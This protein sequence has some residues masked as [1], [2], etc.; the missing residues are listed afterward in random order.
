MKKYFFI[1]SIFLII[2]FFLTGFSSSNGL[3]NFYFVIAIALDTSDSGI[4]LS[5]QIPSNSTQDSSGDSSSSQSSEY[6]LYSVEGETV[7]ECIS[8]LDNY[9][10]KEINLSHCSALIF[11]ENLAKQGLQTYINTF[12]NNTQLRHSC[13]III[14]SSTAFDILKNISNSGAIFSARLY[15]Y[16][17]SSSEYTGYTIKST[18]GEFFQALENDYYEPTAIYAMTS[19]DIVQTTGMAVFKSDSMIGTLDISNTISHLIAINK[20]DSAT[21]TLNNPF[22]VGEKIDLDINLYKSTD[23][24]VDIIN[25]SPLISINVY[26][27]GSI[28]SS[29]T[30]FNYIEGKNIKEVENATNKYLEKIFKKYVYTITKEYNSDIVGF[31]GICQSNYLTKEEFEK[32]HWDEIFK[33][34]YYNININTKINSSNLFNKQ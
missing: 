17:T 3:D 1:I 16:L 7:D 13:N 30:I 2:L 26:P 6:Q 23:I 19:N 4:K 33:D 22:S 8:I 21:I 29:G 34:S 11:S 10:N 28:G 31:K 20:L 9:L 5:V 25:G 12:S 32:I 14:S 18:F 27:E 15:D 24:S